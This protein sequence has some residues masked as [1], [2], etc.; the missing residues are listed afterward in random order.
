V[1]LLRVGFLLAVWSFGLLLPGCFSNGGDEPGPPA[2]PRKLEATAESS[3]SVRLSWQPVADADRIIVYRGGASGPLTRIGQVAGNETGAINTGL[4]PPNPAN[5]INDS[6]YGGGTI[7]VDVRNVGCTGVA[8]CS[9]PGA[10]TTVSLEDGGVVSADLRGFDTS[11]ITMTGGTIGSDFV[12]HHSSSI[13]MSGG[14]VNGV[15]A[16]TGMGTIVWTGGTVG[17]SLMAQ[18]ASLI[19]IVGTGS[20]VNGV[21]VPFGDVVELTGQLTGTLVLGEPIN[22]T[23]YQGGSSYAGTIRLVPEPSTALLLAFGL[24]GIAAGRRR[25]VT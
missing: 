9:S 20:M 17:D 14:M 11:I 19:E 15:L 2:A 24:V 18:G 25:R 7:T 21:P 5:V 1:G 16:A 8:P 13:T 12:R 22:N 3:S 23:F 4:A 6:T 10:P